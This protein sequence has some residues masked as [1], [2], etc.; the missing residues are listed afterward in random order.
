MGELRKDM[1]LL[2]LATKED[3]GELRKD[4]DLL[5]LATKEDMKKLRVEIDSKFEKFKNELLIKL[6]AMVVGCS[7][8]LGTLSTVLAHV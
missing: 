8:I 5:R 1:D 3:M 7:V 2:R 4:M 6:G